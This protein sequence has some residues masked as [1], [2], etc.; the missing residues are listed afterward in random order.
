MQYDQLCRSPLCVYQTR[1]LSINFFLEEKHAN[2]K[3][4]FSQKAGSVVGSRL[5]PSCKNVIRNTF[6]SWSCRSWGL[7]LESPVNVLGSESCWFCIQ[8]QS[9]NNFENDTMKLSVNEAKLISFVGY[10]YNHG[11]KSWDT[12][13]SLG[14]AFSNSHRSSPSPHPTNNVGRGQGDGLLTRCIQNVFRVSTLYRVG[15][16]R[17]ARK[18]RKG[19]TVFRGNR[20][21]TEKYESRSTVPR[22]F[23][24]DCRLSRPE[25]QRFRKCASIPINHPCLSTRKGKRGS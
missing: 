15:G 3:I 24:Q 4:L 7:F 19:C 16:G 12:F 10:T 8:F 13:S 1:I 25:V 5:L 6:L 22:T 14:R 21:M 17:S 2:V 11:Q 18:F 20:Q 9:F 23:V